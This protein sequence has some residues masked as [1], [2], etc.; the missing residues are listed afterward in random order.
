MQTS[1]KKENG[2]TVFLLRRMFIFL[3][4]LAIETSPIIAK[5]LSPK[6]PYDLM[7]E[8]EE[9]AIATWVTQKVRQRELILSTDTVLNEKV[10]GEIAEEEAAYIYKKE[11]AEELLR[12]QANAFHELQIKNL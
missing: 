7:L 4:F 3:L 11:K 2:I 6:G 1:V 12:L 9:S 5:L 10:Y 8:D